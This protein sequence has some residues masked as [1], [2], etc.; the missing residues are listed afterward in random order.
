VAVNPADREGRNGQ[1]LRPAVVLGRRLSE[2][3][4]RD[5]GVLY[6]A[7]PELLGSLGLDPATVDPRADVL[8]GQSG[9]LHFANLS[10]PGTPPTVQPI[11]VAAY[12][13]APTSLGT[14]DGLGRHGWQPR[15]TA[16]WSRRAPRPPAPRS[17]GPARS[18]PTPA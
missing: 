2:R 15:P 12:T 9:D 13:S 10:G 7:T 14:G 6:V 1:V 5:V 16:G 8:T 17:P 4:V 3:T 11:E 18:R